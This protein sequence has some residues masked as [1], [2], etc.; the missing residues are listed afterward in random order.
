MSDQNINKEKTIIQ[1]IP[2]M[3]IGGVENSV[4]ETSSYLKKNNFRPLVLTT[5]GKLI[6]KLNLLGITV[7]K[8]K[9][10]KKNI[11]TIV[12]N[13]FLFKRIFKEKQV[14]LVHA[15]SRAPAWSAYFAA[16]SLGIPFIAT[17]HGHAETRS[18]L[19]RIYNSVLI[20][21]VVVIA[22]SQY[23]T[24]NIK[25]NYKIDSDK[26]ITIPRGV[27][28]N[29]YNQ[30]LFSKNSIKKQR[31]DWLADDTDIILLLPARFSKWKGH[32][33][34]LKALSELK[35]RGLGNNLLL[36]FIGNS[37][38]AKKYLSNLDKAAIKLGI[39]S[40]I[41]IFGSSNNMPLAYQ[42]CDIVLYP[43]TRPEPFG[44][45]PIEA[46]AAGKPIIAS[47]HGGVKETIID[48]VN[49]TGFKVKAGDHL[50]LA[51]KINL[52]VNSDK[53]N[54]NDLKERAINNIKDNFSLNRMC[55]KTLDVYKRILNVSN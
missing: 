28:Y 18:Y 47:N 11:F 45:V 35:K 21:G 12:R 50:D 8:E 27:D 55:K 16:K 49:S 25:K 15:R 17:W 51:E 20:R 33:I 9:I 52:I 7:I 29:D 3:E 23:T 48:G 44:R 6:E 54:K 41:K 38:R 24:N 22:N 37:N 5:G 14:E 36:I 40:Q 30:E 26:I 4:I 2:N 34:A 39:K 32:K 1:I 53:K 31:D 42:A 13:I 46:Q 43:S 10:D 19:K